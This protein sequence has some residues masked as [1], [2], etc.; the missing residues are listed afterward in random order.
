MKKIF[1]V[2]ICVALL[3]ST[4]CSQVNLQKGPSEKPTIIPTTKPTTIPTI[5]STTKPTTKPTTRPTTKPTALPI[6]KPDS[7]ILNGDLK[8]IIQKIYDTSHVQIP[9]TAFT[10]VTTENSKYYLGTDHVEYIEAVVSEPLIDAIAHSVVL[11]RVKAGSDINKIK[12]D[13]K[14]N[15]DPRKWICTGVDPDNVI[16]DNIGN[17]IILIMSNDA[18]KLHEAFLALSK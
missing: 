14:N 6:A 4:A 13:I 2:F 10:Q 9:E 12:E 16:V 3:I 5:V 8:S 11:L 18:A 17:L 15:V 7:N 1:L